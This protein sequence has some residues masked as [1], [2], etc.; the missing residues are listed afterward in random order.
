MAALAHLGRYFLSCSQWTELGTDVAAS[1][2]VDVTNALILHPFVMV[3]LAI[4]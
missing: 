3:A 2:K 1:F 4:F